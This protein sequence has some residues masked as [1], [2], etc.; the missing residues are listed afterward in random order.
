LSQQQ[1]AKDDDDGK[2]SSHHQA[3]I[4]VDTLSFS[5]PILAEKL[6]SL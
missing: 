5:P 1:T 4:H 6:E 2:T 3:V